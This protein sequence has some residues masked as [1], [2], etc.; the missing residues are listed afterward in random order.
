M[1]QIKAAVVEVQARA[2]KK[3]I[4]LIKACTQC[5]RAKLFVVFFNLAQTEGN[6][7]IKFDLKLF[8]YSLGV[9]I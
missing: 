7:Q 5:P 8:V 1:I 3:E 4:T 2:P 9:E 6:M